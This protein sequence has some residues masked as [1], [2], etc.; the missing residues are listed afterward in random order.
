M[1]DTEKKYS[2]VCFDI[3]GTLYSSALLK[4]Y[5]FFFALKLPKLCR[6]YGQMRTEFRNRQT[7]FENSDLADLSF[8]EREAAM[9]Y[10]ISKMP[11][12]CIRRHFETVEE[13]RDFLDAKYYENLKRIFRRL[14]HQRKSIHTLEKLKRNNV[15]IGVFSDWPLWSKLEQMGL[16]PYIDFAACPDDIG[17]LKPDKRCMEYV[18]KNLNADKNSTL[19]VGDSYDKDVI[20]AVNSG[21]D[22]VLV[23]CDE[24][25]YN[26][27]KL[28]KALKVFENWNRFDNW[29]FEHI[30]LQEVCNDT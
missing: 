30:Q 18:I 22:A 2:M 8:R 10:E 16:S 15:K 3:D 19:Y 20:G 4:R 21:I 11:D 14:G 25:K 29:L 26:V 5:M 9:F 17:Y 24:K 27:Q 12:F 1:N 28:P 13:A 23:Y 6:A 7:D